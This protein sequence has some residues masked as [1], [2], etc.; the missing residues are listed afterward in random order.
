MPNVL[1]GTITANTFDALSA[2]VREA[3]ASEADIFGYGIWTHHI[4]KVVENARLL[5]DDFDADV[6][7]VELAALLHDYAS[8]K[9]KA[10]YE[11]HHITA[12]RS[13]STSHPVR[14]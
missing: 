6:G 11:Q 7:I 1:H 2:I 3:C 14:K 8:V 10:L 12:N 9:N 4:V 13:R 5:A